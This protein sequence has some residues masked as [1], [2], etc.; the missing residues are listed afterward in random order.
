[1]EKQPL[2]E[3]ELDNL[4]KIL[5]AD[6]YEFYERQFSN[7]LDM[8]PEH[9]K[10]IDCPLELTFNLSINILE[11]DTEGRNI[12]SAGLSNYTYHI[13][14]PTGQDHQQYIQTFISHFEQAMLQ[15][16][17]KAEQIPNKEERLT[18]E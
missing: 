16:S 17:D 7:Q 6:S 14:V 3:E 4:K 10:L 8:F 15:A 2:T 12:G 18:N 1:M 13:P 9:T 5:P 11:Q